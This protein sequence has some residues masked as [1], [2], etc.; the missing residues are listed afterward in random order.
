MRNLLDDLRHAPTPLALVSRDNLVQQI[1][2]TYVSLFNA[3]SGRTEFAAAEASH[4][5]RYALWLEDAVLS[6]DLSS[7]D[8]E[9]ALNVASTA[10]EFAGR[11]NVNDAPTS[12]FAPESM[13]CCEALSL[14]PWVRT[15][16]KPYK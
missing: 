13:I 10:Y 3:A 2:A 16:L 1:K 11:L 4:L 7:R 5:R 6:N 15:R 9:S 12:I 8:M 14:V